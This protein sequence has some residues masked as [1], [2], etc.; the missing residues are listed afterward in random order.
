MIA[1][2]QN[3]AKRTITNQFKKEES[4][5]ILRRQKKKKKNLLIWPLIDAGT[6]LYMTQLKSC[7]ILTY[8]IIT[9]GASVMTQKQL[10]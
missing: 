9:R 10:N 1:C 4:I 6:K 5:D 7:T 2:T 3:S 8:G